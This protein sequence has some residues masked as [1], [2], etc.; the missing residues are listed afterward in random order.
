MDLYIRARR[1]LPFITGS[2][3]AAERKKILSRALKDVPEEQRK[4]FIELLR[5]AL[6]NSSTPEASVSP[7]P[8]R[9]IHVYSNQGISAQLEWANVDLE[10][11]DLD[12]FGRTLSE[13][14][15]RFAQTTQSG[16]EEFA[17]RFKL[18]AGR[19]LKAEKCSWP[20]TLSCDQK[21]RLVIPAN[22]MILNNTVLL[23]LDSRALSAVAQTHSDFAALVVATVR[24]K[25]AQYQINLHDCFTPLCNSWTCEL[26]LWERQQLNHATID[27]ECLSRILFPGAPPNA[28]DFYTR[29]KILLHQ[30]KLR[31][32]YVPDDGVCFCDVDAND[33]ERLCPGHR[34]PDWTAP[35]LPKPGYVIAQNRKR[36]VQPVAEIWTS[37]QFESAQLEIHTIFRMTLLLGDNDECAHKSLWYT[38]APV[39]MGKSY[40]QGAVTITMLDLQT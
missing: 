40:K 36:E 14:G 29:S 4:E 12:E 10:N 22:N 2:R 28:L 16:R 31:M 20:D 7:P 39:L 23:S 38:F 21:H 33:F 19:R 15:P 5:S 17:K 3:D 34:T 8:A 18:A 25:A 11:L 32:D 27:K 6:A 1:L 13:F 24:I 9:I 37:E 26:C 30:N 35:T